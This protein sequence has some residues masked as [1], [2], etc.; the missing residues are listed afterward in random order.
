VTFSH[1][2][3]CSAPHV[4]YQRYLFVVLGCW[5]VYQ[6]VKPGFDKRPKLKHKQ[7]T[8]TQPFISHWRWL[9][10]L[11]PDDFA[12]YYRAFKHAVVMVMAKSIAVLGRLCAHLQ[13]NCGN[14]FYACPRIA[15]E[16]HCT[17]KMLHGYNTA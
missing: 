10:L 11:A 1:I 5:N 3:D 2:V 6:G 13:N 16:L 8:Q 7:R 15:I 4:I 9:F 14:V 12:N 17:V